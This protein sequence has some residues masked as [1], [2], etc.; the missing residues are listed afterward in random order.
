VDDWCDFEW[1][2]LDREL[3][4]RERLILARPSEQLEILRPLV[5]KARCERVGVYDLS[6]AAGLVRLLERDCCARDKFDSI[7]EK[8]VHAIE[9]AQNR[10]L[11][12]KGKAF[13]DGCKKKG[14]LDALGRLMKEALEVFRAANQR[15]PSAKE[16]WA[17]MPDGREDGTIQEK[18]DDVLCWINDAGL[19]NDTSFHRFENSLSNLKKS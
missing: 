12:L 4:L 16:L 1:P 14:R 6:M 18:V 13:T 5:K 17:I 11:V 9:D 2:D 10:P 3:T 8:L 7:I 19:E 15:D